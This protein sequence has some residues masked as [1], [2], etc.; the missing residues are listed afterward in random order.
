MTFE[1]WK[2]KQYYS[3]TLTT[4]KKHIYA[5]C[6]AHQY[7]SYSGINQ[8]QF[9]V[10]PA[11]SAL[12]WLRNNYTVAINTTYHYVCIL[13]H[14]KLLCYWIRM[15]YYASTCVA[16]SFSLSLIDKEITE[17]DWAHISLLAVVLTSCSVVIT[18]SIVSS[19][20]FRCVAMFAVYCLVVT[21][22]SEETRNIQWF[23]SSSI[24][25]VH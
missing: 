23:V 6:C 1:K 19:H 14:H 16:T 24:D 3:P 7:Y 2:I 9:S 22:F 20:F 11:A 21:K 17:I 4:R 15:G 5:L 13:N 8:T 18:W 12:H 25:W 10:L